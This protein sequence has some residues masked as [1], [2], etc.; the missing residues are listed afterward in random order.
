[1]N[2]NV[3]Y[4]RTAFREKGGGFMVI[5]GGVGGRVGIYFVVVVEVYSF[6]ST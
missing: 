1:M 6:C 2:F 5:V 3:F 4:K